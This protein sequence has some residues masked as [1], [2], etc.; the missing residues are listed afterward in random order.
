LIPEFLAA[1]GRTYEP[2]VPMLGVNATMTEKPA[3]NVHGLAW[4]SYYNC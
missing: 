2:I 4:P 1:G 3:I